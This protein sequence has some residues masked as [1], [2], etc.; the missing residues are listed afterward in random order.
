MLPITDI[1]DVK[2]KPHKGINDPEFFERMEKMKEEKLKEE[3]LKEEKQKEEKK[4]E[5]PR[6]DS[7]NGNRSYYS[8]GYN[9]DRKYNGYRDRDRDRSYYNNRPRIYFNSKKEFPPL[10]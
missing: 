8:N 7:D 6:N 9:D 5:K 2:I 1:I 3:K 10:S 4:N